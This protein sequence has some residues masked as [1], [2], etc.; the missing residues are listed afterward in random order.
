MIVV[1]APTGNIGRVLV[2][3]LIAAG[4]PIRLIARDPSKLPAAVRDQAEVVTGSH[5]DPAVI[6]RALQGADQLFWLPTADFGAATVEEAFVGFSQPA[7]DAIRRHGV[8]RVVSIS[9][10]GR[11]TPAGAH[12]GHVTATLAVDDAIMKT[13][14]AFRALTM[15]SF[16]DNVLRQVAPIRDQGVFFGVVDGARRQPTVATRDI[17]AVAARLLLDGSWTGQAEV[18]LLGP[19]DLSQ[20]DE[21]A[22][23]TEVLGRPVR[24]QRIPDQAFKDQLMSRGTSE[25]MAQA[26]LDMADAKEHGLDEGVARTPQNAIDT[27]T[28]FRQWCEDTLRPAVLG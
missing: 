24:Y 7:V 12:A 21:A 11:G 6:D 2:E 28:T 4:Q 19:E 3:R 5:A 15:P 25:A 10:L 14:V 1:T 23:M 17:A 27:P 16:M 26:M 9:G 13:G 8:K 22:I 20:D 18:P